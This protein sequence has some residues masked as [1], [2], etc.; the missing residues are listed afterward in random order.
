[1]RRGDARRAMAPNGAATAMR[2]VRTGG[3]ATAPSGRG[4]D[5]SISMGI[6]ARTRLGQSPGAPRP[7]VPPH[8]GRRLPHAGDPC[9]KA[10]YVPGFRGLQPG[11]R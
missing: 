1:M 6:G 10:R 3:L 7:R 2:S 8:G 11:F 9:P 4:V 5:S